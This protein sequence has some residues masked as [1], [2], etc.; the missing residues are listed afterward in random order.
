MLLF[1]LYSKVNQL[2]RCMRAR[3]LSH[4][5]CVRLCVTLCDPM[6][7]S[8]PGS[9]GHGILQERM[10]EWIAMLSSG[11]SSWL[12]IKPIHIHIFPLFWISF[13]FR[14]SQCTEWGALSY[15]VGCNNFKWSIIYKNIASQC[16]WDEYN[17]INQQYFKWKKKGGPVAK[18]PCSQCRA[19]RFDPW[20]GN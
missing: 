17:I 20:S 1:L 11:G 9:S 13:L 14:S 8:P 2:Y 10:L 3:M 15:T 4:F 18:T 5:S 7:C 19:L 6:D 12:G 16:C